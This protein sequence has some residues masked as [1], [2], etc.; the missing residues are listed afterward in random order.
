MVVSHLM[1]V[2]MLRESEAAFVG[3]R[4]SAIGTCRLRRCHFR[5]HVRVNLEAI[6]H[7]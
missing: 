4:E 1:V 7:V 5:R 6:A 2:L 3:K